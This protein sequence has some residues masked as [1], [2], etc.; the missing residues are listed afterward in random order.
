[1]ENLAGSQTMRFYVSGRSGKEQLESNASMGVAELRRDGFTSVSA[2][3]DD[4]AA[5]ESQAVLTTQPVRFAKDRTI[6][7]VNVEGEA[8]ALKVA[9]LDAQTLMPLPGLETGMSK[10]E[11][12]RVAVDFPEA[13]IRSVA[14]RPIR[15]RFTFASSSAHLYSFWFAKDACGASQGWIAAG[16]AGFNSSRDWVGS[17]S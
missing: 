14:S 7:F 5:A 2:A 9:I 13:S 15:V 16:G 4:N 6:M 1:M 17:C 8:S 10:G 12:E 3:G 11:G